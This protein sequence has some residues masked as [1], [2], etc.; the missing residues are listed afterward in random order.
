[1]S[2]SKVKKLLLESFSR[3][4]DEIFSLNEFHELIDS[5]KR[6]EL[7]MAL[8]LLHLTFTSGMRLTYG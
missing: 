7:N 8:M 3:T 6:F 4:T 1:M 5:K 2:A